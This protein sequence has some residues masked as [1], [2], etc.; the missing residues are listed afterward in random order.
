MYLKW[1]QKYNL[2]AFEEIDSTNNEAKRLIQSGALDKLVIW[3]RQQ[4]NGRGRYNRVWQSQ[5]G[6]LYLSVLLPIQC[7][8]EKAAELSFVMGLAVYDFITYFAKE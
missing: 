7:P 3:S 1:L 2:L 6:N 4:T 5:D 8:L